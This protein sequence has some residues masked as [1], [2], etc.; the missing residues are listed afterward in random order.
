MIIAIAN[1]QSTRRNHDHMLA[2]RAVDRPGQRRILWDVSQLAAEPTALV[3][4]ARSL[5][6]PTGWTPRRR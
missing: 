1:K 6:T 3:L 4:T 5:I 2:Q